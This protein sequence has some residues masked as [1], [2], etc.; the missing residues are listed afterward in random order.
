MTG[1]NFTDGVQRALQSAREEAAARQERNVTPEHLLLGVLRH[2]GPDCE[3]ALTHLKVDPEIV[4][5]ELASAMSAASQERTVEGDF[6][7]TAAS[8]RV[9]K[10]AMKEAGDLGYAWIGTE[11]IL[12]ALAHEGSPPIGKL[13]ASHRLT[14]D[15]LRDVL[16]RWTPPRG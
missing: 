15:R 16:A 11:H 14:V 5:K 6:P 9:L 3:T 1:Y 13:F 8:M 10:T 4:S 7:Y 2:R 12:L